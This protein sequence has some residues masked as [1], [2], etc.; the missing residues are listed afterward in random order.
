MTLRVARIRGNRRS[1]TLSL[2]Q[3]ETSA[4]WLQ[5]AANALYNDAAAAALHLASIRVDESS[6]LY[7]AKSGSSVN[8]AGSLW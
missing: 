8:H 6:T 3:H 2:T 7:G 1:D 4:P 5:Q